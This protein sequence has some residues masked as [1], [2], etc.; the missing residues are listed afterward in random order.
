M[1]LYEYFG[2]SGFHTCL[3][4]TFG[5]DFDAYENVIFSRARGAGCHNNLLI[6]DDRMLSLAL[7]GNSSLP[8]HA[9]RLYTVTGAT[10]K[11]VFHPKVALQLGRSGGRMIV[12]SANTTSAGLAGNLEIAGVV[13]CAAEPS[14]ERQ[15]VNAAFRYLTRFLDDRDPGIQQ[16]IDW[17]RTRTPWLM[18]DGPT[19]GIVTLKDGTHAAF[20]A[21]GGSQGIAGQFL[22]A[23]GDEKAERLIVVSP[24]W[25]DDLAAINHLVDATAVAE[26]VILLDEGRHVFPPDALDQSWPISLRNF[27]APDEN[28]FVHAKLIIVQTAQADHVL[29]GSANCTVA[30]LGNTSFAGI[31]EEACLYR[32]LP[33]NAVIEKLGLAAALEAPPIDRTAIAS[34]PPD[35]P[36][37]LNDLSARNPGRFSCL[38]DTLTWR[39][40]EGANVDDSQLEFLNVGGEIVAVTLHPLPSTET[41]ERR[42]RLAVADSDRPSF[43]RLRYTDGNLSAPAVILI[44]DA[45]RAAV[46]DPRT[47]RVDA[48]LAMLDGETDVS[49]WLLET[50]SELEAADTALRQ[51]APIKRQ[52]PTRTSSEPDQSVAYATLN[53]ESFVAGRQLRSDTGALSRD[54]LSGTN[55]SYIRGFLNRIL[56]LNGPSLDPDGNAD[57]EGITAA[58][59]LGDDVADATK[60]LEAGE[61][62]T[63][64]PD[65]PKPPS[66]DPDLERQMEQRRTQ[67]RRANRDQLIGA[68]ANLQKQI[69]DKAQLTAIDLLRLR[70][71]LMVILAAGWDGQTRPASPLHVLPASGDTNG[72]WPR[73]LGKCLFAYFGGAAPPVRRLVIED[74][75]DQIPDDILEC[76]A[77]CLWSIQAIL[78]AGGQI[79]EYKAL[80]A[81]FQKLGTAIYVQTGLRQDEFFDARVMKTFD[82]LSQRFSQLLKVNPDRMKAGHRAAAVSLRSAAGQS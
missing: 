31:N 80:M 44:R 52:K 17:M 68:V 73:L 45:L 8:R 53:Y 59:D 54:S 1:K 5:V 50:L 32:A 77:G 36:I 56:A 7:D 82:A 78:E 69:A 25:D 61:D 16:Q 28:R 57:S 41:S 12:S 65:A 6:V 39:P 14:G 46:R 20:I 66:A 11:G 64:A 70:A 19:P 71:M 15:L 34:I 40:P 29:Y 62:F 37:P 55:L 24:Y 4:T 67:Q 75:Y 58:F 33:P 27:K 60:A 51:G 79:G 38:F 49:L 48:A 13:E 21:S 30:A 9:G 26:A 3:V 42:Y 35:E 81:A 18:E 74:Y 76:W 47:K 23:I 10:A 43:A 22:A 2:K 63:P 72:A